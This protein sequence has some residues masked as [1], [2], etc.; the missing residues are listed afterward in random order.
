MVFHVEIFVR[1]YIV[2]VDD[3]A[4]EATRFVHK[5]K[6]ET[7]KAIE[8]GKEFVDRAKNEAE[9]A[10]EE[11]KSGFEEIKEGFEE[12]VGKA[13]EVGKEIWEDIKGIFDHRESEGNK[14]DKVKVN[15]TT[16]AARHRRAFN[17]V[18]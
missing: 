10:V 18:S 15:S 6:N 7:E 9:K 16:R 11:G 14:T 13:E 8:D 4:N 2:D 3:L 17:Y 12:I 5:A 1:A